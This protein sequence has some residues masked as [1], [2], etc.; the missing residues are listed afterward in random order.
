MSFKRVCTDCWWDFSLLPF[1]WLVD[2]GTYCKHCQD[3]R[4]SVARDEVDEEEAEEI[5]EDRRERA[6]TDGSR[7]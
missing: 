5:M 3:L 6:F 1:R 7:W 2:R 4:M